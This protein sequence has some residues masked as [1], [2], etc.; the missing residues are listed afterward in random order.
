MVLFVE[1][2]TSAYE[3][4]LSVCASD[5][6]G[7]AVRLV[8]CRPELGEGAAVEDPCERPENPAVCDDE[9]GPGLALERD[10]RLV[11]KAAE[12]GLDRRE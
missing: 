2:H 12:S 5:A 6:M 9:N 7:A 10:D 1:E 4:E 8:V 3:R 11:E